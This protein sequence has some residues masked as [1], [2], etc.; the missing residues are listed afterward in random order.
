LGL[1]YELQCH[2]F[3]GMVY[4]FETCMLAFSFINV[5]FFVLFL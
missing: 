2:G 5:V 3:V 4:F 1:E